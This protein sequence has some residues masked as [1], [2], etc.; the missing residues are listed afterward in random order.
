MHLSARN[1]AQVYLFHVSF[2]YI[3]LAARRMPQTLGDDP[4]WGKADF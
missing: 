3:Q 1:K 2:N 4:N